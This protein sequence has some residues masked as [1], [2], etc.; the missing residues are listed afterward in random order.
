MES[1]TAEICLAPIILKC[2]YYS[3][4]IQGILI[5]LFLYGFSYQ[6]HRNYKVW[7]RYW[8]A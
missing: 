5:G 1:E 8:G 7:K 3:A 2:V 4:Y 6:V